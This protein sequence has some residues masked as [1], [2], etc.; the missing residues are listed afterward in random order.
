MA[1]ISM[2]THVGEPIQTRHATVTPE[3]RALII[4]WPG[5]GVVW[6]RPTAV[7]VERDGRI[8]RHPIVDVT[9]TTQI[10]LIVAG[11]SFMLI[12]AVL[13]RSRRNTH[14]SRSE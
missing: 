4:E 3:S 9:R 7:T 10:A 5:G 2:G 14:A 11:L 1:K 8:E 6:N 13:M 12:S